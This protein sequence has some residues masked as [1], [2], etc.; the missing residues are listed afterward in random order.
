MVVHLSVKT[1]VRV[2][3]QHRQD[4]LFLPLPLLWKFIHPDK[5]NCWQLST[6]SLAMFPS[7]ETLKT[8]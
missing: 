4:Y 3:S 1:V 8:A 2:Q 6:N 7:Q 5:L